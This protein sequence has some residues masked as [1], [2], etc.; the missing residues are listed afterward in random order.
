MR[1]LNQQDDRG[2]AAIFVVLMVP[3][4]AL[5]CSF[6]FDGGRGIVARRQT[7]NAADAGALAKAT[8]CAHLPL[9]IT[10]TNFSRYQNDGAV[11]APDTP[12]T[13]APTCGNGTTTVWMTKNITATFPLLGI[14]PWDVN[15]SATAK[16]GT[17]GGAVT[18]PVVIS[19][20]T[21]DSATANGTTFPSAEVI[22]PLGAGG[23]DCPG[24]PPGSFGWLDTGL[25][26]PCSIET[27]LNSSGQL[28]AHGNTGNGNVNPWDCITQVGVNGSL[29]LPIF[30]ASCNSP[31]PCVV[32][33]ND[34]N[35]FNNY[36]LLLGYAELQITGWNL[37]HGSPRTGG[38]PVPSCPGSGSAS[39]LRGKFIRFSTQDGST[40][41]GGSFGV[42][43]IY[44]S[45]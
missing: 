33:Q 28:V 10:S 12:G 24:R 26:G 42:R 38:S 17:I 37:Q 39:C 13:P 15:R 20:C 44:L 7:Q 5:C 34:G 35:G 31:S 1:R 41:N 32:N 43:V 19:Q 30:G 25:A 9:P 11:L 18:A 4:L 6:V 3:V 40:G 22:I 36:Y 2:V 8:D 27:I 23:A 45:S 29:L 14:G 16:W 21:F